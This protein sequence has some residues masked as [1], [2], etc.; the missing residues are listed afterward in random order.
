MGKWNKAK[1]SRDQFQILAAVLWHSEGFLAEDE[2]NNDENYSRG[3]N[4]LFFIYDFLSFALC[5]LQRPDECLD[6]NQREA[7]W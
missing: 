3:N 7:V 1:S 6:G 2:I 5:Q 4:L